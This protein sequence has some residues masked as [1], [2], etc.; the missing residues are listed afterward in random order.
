MAFMC[1]APAANPWRSI[2]LPAT[3]DGNIFIDPED[4]TTGNFT[5]R[6]N[7]SSAT[8]KNIIG[9]CFEVAGQPHR[10]RFI[11]ATDLNVFL[12]WGNVDSDGRA[13]HGYRRK[14][15]DL[16]SLKFREHMIL[17]DEEWVAT[18]T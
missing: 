4:N 11:V 7:Q 10:I 15:V 14:L 3:D 13:I 6:H 9:R 17:D 1:N 5:G 18:K 8:F 16:S 12:Y 2:I